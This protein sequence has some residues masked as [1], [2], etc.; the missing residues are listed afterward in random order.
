MEQIHGVSLLLLARAFSLFAFHLPHFGLRL[1]T[2]SHPHARHW[3][4]QLC[5]CAAGHPGASPC[6]VPPSPVGCREH[7]WEEGPWLLPTCR[8]C[9]LLRSRQAGNLASAGEDPLTLP[10]Q[11]EIIMWQT[12]FIFILY[13][14]PRVLCSPLD[15]NCGVELAQW[16]NRL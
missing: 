10:W 16:R 14:W 7:C 8:V 4:C 9:F 12:S 3:P 15:R 5:P 11:K 13:A 1:C 6:R 2:P